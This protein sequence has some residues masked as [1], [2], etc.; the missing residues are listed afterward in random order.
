MSGAATLFRKAARSL[1]VGLPAVLAMACVF[2]SPCV[3]ED[4]RPVLPPGCEDLNPPADQHVSFHGYAQGVQVYRWDDATQKWIFVEPVATLYSDAGFGGQIA[5]HFVGPTWQSN[6]G[7]AVVGKKLL[8]RTP[9]PTA[10][11]WLLL[12]GSS[13]HGPGP[14][15]GTTYIQRTSTSGGLAPSGPGTTGQ[16]ASVPYKAEYYFYK[17]D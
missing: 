1:R 3:D 5:T 8:D 17:K 2:P 13:S 7:S 15:D 14:L 16:I 9:D 11:P 4:R 10:I 6:S 12:A